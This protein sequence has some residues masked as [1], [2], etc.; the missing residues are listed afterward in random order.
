[1]KFH[2]KLLMQ[3][4][5]SSFVPVYSIAEKTACFRQVCLHSFTILTTEQ[6]SR[7]SCSILSGHFSEQ[8]HAELEKQIG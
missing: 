8:F 4:I 6:F 5:I 3:S 1:M 2:L 7:S